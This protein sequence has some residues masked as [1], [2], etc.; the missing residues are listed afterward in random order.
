MA[1][2]WTSGEDLPLFSGTPVHAKAQT[3]TAQP[4]TR[5]LSLL[6]CPVCGAGVEYLERERVD[7][8][9][10]YHCERCAALFAEGEAVRQTND[11]TDDSGEETPS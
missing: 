11:A 7:D 10:F 6:R 9:W 5:Q 2:L 8:E 3:F 4:Y 1:L